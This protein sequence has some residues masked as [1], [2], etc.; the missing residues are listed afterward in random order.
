MIL[1][2]WAESQTMKSHRSV[3][4]SFW[5][6]QKTYTLPETNIAP[7]NRPSQKE[8]IVYQPSIFQGQAVSF[9]ED[10][11]WGRLKWFNKNKNNSNNSQK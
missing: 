4:A 8:T 5:H 11:L 2:V 1:Q 3:E 10:T 9:M 6:G 7:E